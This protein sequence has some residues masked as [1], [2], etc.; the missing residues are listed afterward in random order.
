MTDTTT[1]LPLSIPQT[2]HSVIK[3][4][5]NAVAAEMSLN[6]EPDTL[7]TNWRGV[8][9]DPGDMSGRVDLDLLRF[10]NASDIGPRGMGG[11][12]SLDFFILDEADHYDKALRAHSE[13]TFGVG[14]CM[15]PYYEETARES[16][17]F[18]YKMA[19]DMPY[20]DLTWSAPAHKPGEAPRGTKPAFIGGKKKTKQQ[21]AALK[22]RRKQR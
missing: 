7:T 17:M 14:S 6:C 5:R 16:Q 11:G 13:L 12:F 21:R 10:F 19:H 15:I 22:A 4:W 9:L 3:H 18:A 8:V 1:T 20:K 2:E